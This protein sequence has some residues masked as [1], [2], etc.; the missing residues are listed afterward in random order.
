MTERRYALVKISSGDYLLPSNDANTLWRISSY[1][2]DGSAEW[3]GG[4]KLRG[5][6]W[7]TAK[8]RDPL[9]TAGGDMPADFL[10]W[11]RW[12]TWETCIASRGKAI[13]STLR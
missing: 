2:E 12:E 6:Y 3:V 7:Q 4:R 13:E 11:D 5:T 8:Y 10:E 1:L 9:P